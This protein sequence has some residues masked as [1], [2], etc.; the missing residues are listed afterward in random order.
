MLPDKECAFVNY[1]WQEDAVHARSEMQGGR[2]GNC[3]IRI[4]FGKVFPS[5]HLN[6][7]L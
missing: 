1:V 7:F 2:L 4:G 6:D 5:A 3:I